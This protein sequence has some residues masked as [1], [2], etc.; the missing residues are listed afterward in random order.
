MFITII[1]VLDMSRKLLIT[2]A[3]GLGSLATFTAP[4]FGQSFVGEWTATATTAGGDIAETISVAKTADGYAIIAKL[5]VPSG[6]P[7]AGPG[8][9]IVLDGDNFSYKRKLSFPG[10]EVVLTYTGVVSGDTFTGTAEM[11]GFK[12]PYNGVR[13]GK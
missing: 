1:E 7:E 8:E 13:S 10:G 12:V 11:G 4:A 5:V 6:A 9:E 3:L 2:V